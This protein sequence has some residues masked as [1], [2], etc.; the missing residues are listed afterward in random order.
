[1]D[2]GVGLDFGFGLLFGFG[3]DLFEFVFAFVLCEI[4]C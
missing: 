2:E 4:W 1:M 3:L